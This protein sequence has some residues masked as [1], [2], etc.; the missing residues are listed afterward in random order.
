MKLAWG[1]DAKC[2]QQRAEGDR[3]LDE[4]ER[5]VDTLQQVLDERPP[6]TLDEALYQLT[7]RAGE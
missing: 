2:Q 4:A 7:H 5:K 3:M 6:K 1:T